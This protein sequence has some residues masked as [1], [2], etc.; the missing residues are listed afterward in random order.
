MLRSF[1]LL[2]VAS[3]LVGCAPKASDGEASGANAATTAPATTAPRTASASPASSEPSAGA[4]APRAKNFEARGIYITATSMVLPRYVPMLKALKAAGGNTIVFDGKDEGGIVSWQSQVPL[5]KA[6]GAS[7]EG[8]IRD[9]KAKVAEAHKLGIHV[10]GRVVC[11]HDP[12]LAKKRPD[13]AAKRAGGGVWKELGRQSWLD[14]SLTAAQDYNI[15]IA[16]EMVAAGVDEV[17]FDYIRFPAM[18]DTQNARY[19]F[20]ES[21]VKKHE[22][23]TAFL[24]RAREALKP[25]G[26]LV[27]V[28]VYGIMAWAQPIDV[29]ITGQL[30]EDMA[31]HTDVMCP[32][33]YPSHF[34]RGFAGVSNPADQPYLFMHKG[35]TLM[36]KKV[37]GT[38]VVVRPWMQAM[39]YKVTSFT[40]RYI[41][42][43]MRAGRDTK[44]VGYMMWNAQNKY[45]TAFS[46]MASFH[47]MR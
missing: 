31:L 23:I 36:N 12:I 35:L 41:S 47:G 19:G 4:V 33:L 3:L 34:S 25:S 30:L 18:G 6:I 27:S 44:A 9:L 21:K 13:L 46:G 38:G 8:P 45:E 15:D 1:S 43:Q 14:P 32:M 28:D 26:A 17:Q 16:R 29:R 40:P 2:V 10:A 42:E 5:A 11:F 7:K 39:P 22:I 24:K 20:D 37:A